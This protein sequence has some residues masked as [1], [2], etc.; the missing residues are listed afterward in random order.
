MT[1]AVSNRLDV[2][3]VLDDAAT[4]VPTNQ[5]LRAN[6]GAFFQTFATAA[7]AGVHADL[8]VSAPEWCE[9]GTLPLS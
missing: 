2:L 9:D 3:F 5:Q 4:A 7:T 6:V 8:H 1:F